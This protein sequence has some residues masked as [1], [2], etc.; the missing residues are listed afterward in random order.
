MGV[1]GSGVLALIAARGGLTCVVSAGS[2]DR[3]SRCVLSRQ[4]CTASHTPPAARSRPVGSSLRLARRA[5]PWKRPAGVGSRSPGVRRTET[6]DIAESTNDTTGF[7]PLIDNE[8]P[9]LRAG[10]AAGGG[11][12]VGCPLTFSSRQLAPSVTDRDPSCSTRAD[13]RARPSPLQFAS[14]TCAAPCGSSGIFGPTQL[15]APRG[16]KSASSISAGTG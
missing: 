7:A 10:L 12:R 1:G 3:P 8:L 13:R 4:G 6:A 9:R 16:R 15:A 14:L 5:F 2:Q 11:H